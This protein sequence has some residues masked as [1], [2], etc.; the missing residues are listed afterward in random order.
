MVDW[1]VDINIVGFSDCMASLSRLELIS[2]I[3]WPNEFLT[4]AAEITKTNI[5]DRTPVGK[6]G[7]LKASWY[8]EEGPDNRKI[9]STE[10]YGRFVNDGTKPSPGRYVKAIDRRLINKTGKAWKIT[11]E[12]AFELE[13]QKA[14]RITKKRVGSAVVLYTPGTKEAHI[15]TLAAK[16]KL[17]VGKG[18]E[19]YRA[20]RKYLQ[21]K[22]VEVANLEAVDTSLKF[23]G[24]MG[25]RPLGGEE[26][27]TEEEVEGDV[28][29]M[30]AKVPKQGDI[31]MHPGVP[32][33]HYFDD[34]LADADREI[35]EWFKEFANGIGWS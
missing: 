29:W 24:K 21:S 3:R 5:E 11:R 9:G 22:G 34:A 1:R 31:G 15:L 6:T 26:V 32:A 27:P 19:T 20:T 30:E 25:F 16:G 2:R 13:S 14:V 12:K 17:G 28:T 33:T 8:I 35:D 4:R 10:E 7:K 18:T 23:W